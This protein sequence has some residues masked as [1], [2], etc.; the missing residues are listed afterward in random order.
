MPETQ[1]LD[2]SFRGWYRRTL[3]R[4]WIVAQIA[5]WAVYAPALPLAYGVWRYMMWADEWR[6]THGKEATARFDATHT[7]VKPTVT[8]RGRFRRGYWRRK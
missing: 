5:A 1:T 8:K 4:W 2:L 6:R 7:W 3:G